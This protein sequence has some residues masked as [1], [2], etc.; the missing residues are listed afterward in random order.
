[1]TRIR[2]LKRG[3]CVFGGE[4]MGAREMHILRGN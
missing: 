2:Q 1:M 3:A 4:A